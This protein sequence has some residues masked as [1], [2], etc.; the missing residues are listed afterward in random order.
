MTRNLLLFTILSSALLLTSWRYLIVASDEQ[1]GA[2]SELQ[3]TSETWDENKS[4]IPDA[5]LFPKVIQGYAKQGREVYVSLG[6]IAC[7]TQQVRLEQTGNDLARGWGLRPSVP[8]DYIRQSQPLL[9]RFR[10]GPDLTNVG[11]RG[12]L[13][14]EALH[15]HLYSPQADSSESICQPNPFLYTIRAIQGDVSPEA[16]DLGN[17][18]EMVPGR[19]ARKLAAYLGSLRQNY[20]LPEMPNIIEPEI[21]IVPIAPPVPAAASAENNESSDE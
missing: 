18:T 16:Y 4:V 6:C 17:G 14:E 2:S 15:R 5:P 1:F 3:L 11:S 7:H 21:E 9:G 19:S 8:R 12:E 13:D 20:E 10:L